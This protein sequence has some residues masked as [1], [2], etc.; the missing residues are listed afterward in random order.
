M[1]E[2]TL[3]NLMLMV[4][5][6]GTPV[7]IFIGLSIE[8]LIFR[9]RLSKMEGMMPVLRYGGYAFC[10]WWFCLWFISDVIK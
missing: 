10:W 4:L 8:K 1:F 3:D 9:D 2:G 5:I 6:F 7:G